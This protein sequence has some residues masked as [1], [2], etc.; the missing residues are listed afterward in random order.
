VRV[1]RCDA[2][3]CTS[4]LLVGW[5]TG[6]TFATREY[7]V[8]TPPA[9]TDLSWRYQYAVAATDGYGNVGNT[10]AGYA[11]APVLTQ[12]TTSVAYTGVWK[13]ASGSS[14]SGGS[15][16][17]STAV[18]AKATFTFN[19]RSVGFVSFKAL[20]RGKVKIYLDGKLK[21]TFSLANATAQAR[22][23]IYAATTTAATHKLM[24]VVVSGRVDVDAFVV[25][26]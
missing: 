9:P 20:G 18:G 22:R 26:K 16:K 23:I 12:Q 24:L 5:Q 19:G 7:W 25:L 8:A 15:A 3:P 1:G 13:N 17:Y 11:L 2:S 6:T 10:M 21:G 14:Y 4:P